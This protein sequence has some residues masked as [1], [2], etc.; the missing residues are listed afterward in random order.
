MQGKRLKMLGSQLHW[1]SFQTLFTCHRWVAHHVILV[2]PEVIRS[3]VLQIRL[4]YRCDDHCRL[5]DMIDRL[6]TS[7]GSLLHVLKIEASSHHCGSI[8]PLGTV[9]YFYWRGAVATS[10]TPH[11]NTWD[12]P[13][14]KLKKWWPPSLWDLQ[15]SDD[16]PLHM[17]LSWSYLTTML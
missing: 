3:D 11:K 7:L 17:P 12:P 1:T 10:K 15:K 14:T 6:Q 4:I 16:P 5:S 2:H 8:S 13:L 9:H